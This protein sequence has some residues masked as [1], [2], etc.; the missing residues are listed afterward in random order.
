VRTLAW[1]A[2][3]FAAAAF[4]AEYFLPV[5]GLPYFA[6]ALFLLAVVGLLPRIRK[7]QAVLFLAFAGLGTL[8]WWG[9]Y[10][11][12]VLPCEELVGQEVTVT[13]RVTDFAVQGD[14]YE[15]L[16][17]RILD[18]GPKEK[19][20]LYFSDEIL[21]ELT[22]GDIITVTVQVRSALELSGERSHYYTAQNINMRGYV[23]DSIQMTGHWTWSWLYGPQWMCRWVKNQCDSLFSG[24]TAAFMKALLTGDTA[25]LRQ[26]ESLYGAMRRAGVLH[27]VAISGMHI[28]VLTA[29]VQTV[30]GGKRVRLLCVPVLVLF[31]LMSGCRPS[32]VRAVVMQSFWLLAPLFRRENDPPTSLMGALL[33]LLAV[34]PMAIAGVG[35]QLSFLCMAGNALLIPRLTVWAQAHLPEEGWYARPLQILW[36]SVACSLSTSVFTMPVAAWYFGSVPLLSP[37]SNLLT[38]WV[39]EICFAAG[40]VVCLVGGLVPALGTLLAVPLGWTVSGCIFVYKT[41]AAVPYGCLYVMKD[42]AVLWLVA[43]Y[44]LFILWFALKRRYHALRSIIPAELCVIGLCW[45]L[46]SEG[47]SLGA[48]QATL[49][50]LDV[51]QGQCIVLTDDTASIVIDCGGS[52]QTSAGDT[53]AEYLLAAGKNHV[54]M[55]ILTHLHDD[56]ANGVVQLLERME[57]SYLVMPAGTEGESALWEPIVAAAEQAGTAVVSLSQACLA[58][59]GDMEL[60]LYLPE[61]SSDINERGIVIL[62][63]MGGQSALIM[64]DAGTSSELVLIGQGLV[65]DVDVLVAGHHGSDTASGVLFLKAAQAETAIISVGRN[66][67]GLPDEEIVERLGDYCQQ[68]LRTDEQ[69]TITVTMQEG[70]KSYG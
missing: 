1:S 26:Q 27:V 57:V 28:A 53:A 6:A 44:G 35:L 45:V 2:G 17:V 70:D 68:V 42:G 49:A 5:E 4:L 33:I 11:A 62:A 61:G 34:N 29:F 39:I 15:T 25:D 32:V 48:E 50:A 69:G 47:L 56:H 60:Q 13:A 43:S 21:P 41:I 67:Y 59:A 36:T 23:Q 55:L 40:Y 54:D 16:T 9:H 20:V 3:G 12:H 58:Q 14:G 65:P 52:G 66:N 63:Q 31:M 10:T 38:L 18:G 8:A 64:G 37:L 46:V 51:G 30:F 19:A 7:G 24:E 22:P